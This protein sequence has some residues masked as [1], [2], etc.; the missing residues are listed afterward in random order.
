[1]DEKTVLSDVAVTTDWTEF[2]LTGG[3]AV[4]HNVR[5]QA[6]TNHDGIFLLCGVP[7][8]VQLELRAEAGGF[9]V[10]PVLLTAND[11]LIRRVDFAVSLRDS[12][13]RNVAPS[14]SAMVTRGTVGTASLRGVLLG[15]DGQPVREALLSILG[16][17]LS[18]RSNATGAFRV[19]QIPAGTRTIE[20]R[21]IGL[22]PMTFSVDF[23]TNASRDT[24]LS[25][26]RQAQTLKQVAVSG[27]ARS[28]S[29]MENDGFNLRRLQGLGKFATAEDLARHPAL[30]LATSIAAVGGVHVE[31]VGGYPMPY[32][33]GTKGT[34]C[35]PN[36]FIDGV[37]Y[38]VDGVSPFARGE[39]HLFSDLSAMVSP[40][41]IKGVEVYSNPGTLPARYDRSS[42]TGCG[43]VVI[44]TR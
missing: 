29:P 13:A 17:Q 33:R 23:A 34:N 20:V 36:Y 28:M 26:G 12:A 9:S 18:S 7:T 44:W 16:T 10:G 27:R 37:P 5:A 38:A 31:Y 21:S 15:G 14:D 32:L 8:T 40:E 6:R 2:T 25:I 43:S 1:V 41:S 30:D 11:R 42:S 39:G 35:I 19:D 4:G 3:R 24:T 22:V